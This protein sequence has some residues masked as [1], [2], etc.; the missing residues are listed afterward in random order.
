MFYAVEMGIPFFIY[1]P[2]A[3]GRHINKKGV[4]GEFIRIRDHKYG[5]YIENLFSACPDVEIT[6]EQRTVVEQEVGVD[7]AMDRDEL[8]RLLMDNYWRQ[9]VEDAVRFPFRH[10]KKFFQRMFR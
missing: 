1:G 9:R 7:D 10:P 8:Y 3:H 5:E 6:E 2:E 4:P